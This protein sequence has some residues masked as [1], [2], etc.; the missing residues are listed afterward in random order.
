[1]TIIVQISLEA[2]SVQWRLQDLQTRG[3]VGW[4]LLKQ[5]PTSPSV[6]ANECARRFMGDATGGRWGQILNRGGTGL[7][8]PIIMEP[9]VDAV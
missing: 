5:R 6:A 1:M 2:R 9:P 8:D 4:P 7:P 3:P